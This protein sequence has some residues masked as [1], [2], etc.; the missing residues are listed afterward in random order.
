[1]TLIRGRREN[2]T[3]ICARSDGGASEIAASGDGIPLVVA[4]EGEGGV[5]AERVGDEAAAAL[6]DGGAVGSPVAAGI[7][8]GELQR[9]LGDGGAG[10]AP[11]PARWSG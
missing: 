3:G 6:L 8:E 11:A 2:L 5:V 10:D 7:V 9:G 1:M 4:V